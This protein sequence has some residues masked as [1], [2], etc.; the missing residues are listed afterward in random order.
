MQFMRANDRPSDVITIQLKLH[1]KSREEENRK[2]KK[3]K[4]EDTGSVALFKMFSLSAGKARMKT[5]AMSS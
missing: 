5:T 4:K 2:K 3:K 1:A